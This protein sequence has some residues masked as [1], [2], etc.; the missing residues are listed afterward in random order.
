MI[1]YDDILSNM[2]LSTERAKMQITKVVHISKIA[3]L[4]LA[5]HLVGNQAIIF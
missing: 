2:I 4:E 1:Q 5:N 3:I